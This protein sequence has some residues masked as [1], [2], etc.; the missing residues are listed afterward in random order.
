MKTCC[1]GPGKTAFTENDWA[2]MPPH[3]VGE[4]TYQVRMKNCARQSIGNNHE[5]TIIQW[6]SQFI[7]EELHHKAAR[8]MTSVEDERANKGSIE[9]QTYNAGGSRMIKIHSAV[10][11]GGESKKKVSRLADRLSGKKACLVV[12]VNHSVVSVA[13][14]CCCLV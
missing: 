6:K 8:K 11:G 10:P 13:D 5:H 4:K 14:L 12:S 7:E 2:A 1:T 9:R 3:E